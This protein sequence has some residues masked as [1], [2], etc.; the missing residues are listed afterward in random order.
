MHIDGEH[1]FFNFEFEERRTSDFL[2][3]NTL[4]LSRQDGKFG[5]IDSYGNVVVEHI[6]DD[7]NRTKHI[8]VCSS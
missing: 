8:W 3:S 4:F 1:R 2:T 7:R 5:F 6:Y